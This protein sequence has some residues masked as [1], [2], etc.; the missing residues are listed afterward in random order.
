MGILAQI[1]ISLVM[2]VAAFLLMPKPKAMS[3]ADPEGLEDPKASAGSPLKV[4]F[5][6]K[7]IK[8]PNIL[9]FG[10]KSTRTYKVKA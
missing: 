7:T 8:D 2:M 6:T 9:W 3:N 1:L 5:G 10:D 4:V